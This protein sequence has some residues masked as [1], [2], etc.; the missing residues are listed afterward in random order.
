MKKIIAM[1]LV[2]AMALAL[3]ACGASAPAAT[4]DPKAEEPKTETPVVETPA[5]AK[6]YEGVELTYWS[7][8]NEAEPQGKVIVEAVAAFEAETGAKVNVEW[9]GRDLNT[10]IT[11][12]LEAKE[13]V[14]IFDD[15]Y[16]RI[17]TAYAAHTYDLT[18]MAEAAGYADYSYACFNDFVVNTA[19]Y[20]NCIVE[21][22]QIG[23]IFYNKDA[24]AE[25]GIETVPTTWAEKL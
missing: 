24:F 15:D 5:E 4:E 3:V 7:M 25:A 8:W 19:G 12:A 13:N 14:D 2:L 18:E 6:K 20:L 23:G 21:Q 22:P 16:A 9:K 10:V 17:T 11:A 1:L